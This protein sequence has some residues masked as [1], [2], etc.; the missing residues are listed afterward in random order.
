MK[1]FTIFWALFI[2]TT[3]GA[4][5]AQFRN[6]NPDHIDDKETTTVVRLTPEM[7]S[8]QL[9]LPKLSPFPTNNFQL[10]ETKTTQVL[11]FISSEVVRK[12][13]DLG[14]F[15]PA[16]YPRTVMEYSNA[17]RRKMFDAEPTNQQRRSPRIFRFN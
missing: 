17:V 8:D 5:F 9:S 12:K 16:P 2:V 6:L 10:P 14:Y 4:G 3:T 13:F 15:S 1:A 11:L 7:F